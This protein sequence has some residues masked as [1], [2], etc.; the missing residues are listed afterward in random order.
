MVHETMS[1][2]TKNPNQIKG[3]QVTGRALCLGRSVRM[4]PIE[5]VDRDRNI[6]PGPVVTGSLQLAKRSGKK[7]QTMLGHIILFVD[8]RTSF[9]WP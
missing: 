2:R 5:S 1:Q 6:P 7:K 4:F 9:L 3:I 8:F